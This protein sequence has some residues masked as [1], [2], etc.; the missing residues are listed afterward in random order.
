MRG[1]ILKKKLMVL[2]AVAIMISTC[3]T[4][5]KMNSGK[6]RFGSAGIG[7]TYQIFG[8]TFANLISSKSKKYNI[9]VKTTAGS[10]ANLRL[11]SKDYIQMAVAQMDLINDAY[12][13]TGIFENDKKYQGYRAVASLYT[14][15]CQIVVPA[16]SDI[17]SMDDLEGK[18]VCIGEEESGTEQNALQILNA[19]GLNERLVDTVNLNYTDAAK[20]LKSGDIDAFFCTAGVQT[21]VINELSKQCKIRLVSLD[22]KGVSRLKKSYKFYTEYTIPAGTYVNQTKEIKTVGVK[23]V[24]LASDKLSEDTV[25][26]ITQILFKNQQQIQYALPVDISLDETT[27]VAGITI[28]FHDGAAAYYK[29]HGITVN[30]EKGSN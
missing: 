28:P 20:K 26:D 24:L 22:Q 29:Q 13:R 6:I 17:Q 11:L 5:C 15:A 30:T 4:G 7:G 18:K 8:D 12:N 21:T 27:A 3:L 23:A 14:E 25:K 1:D 9:E 19:Y 16:D 10:A 2:C